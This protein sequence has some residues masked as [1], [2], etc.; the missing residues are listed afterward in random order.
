VQLRNGFLTFVRERAEQ[1]DVFAR[2]ALNYTLMNRLSGT[3]IKERAD[4]VI[5]GRQ[6]VSVEWL[7]QFLVQRFSYHEAQLIRNV[8]TNSFDPVVNLEEM[9]GLISAISKLSHRF[10]GKITLLEVDEFDGNR[11]SIEFV[12]G[13]INS[14]IPA[15]VMLLISTPSGYAEVQNSNPSVFDRLE[16][17][18]Y[19]VDLAGSNSGEELA[20][21]A[22]EYVRHSEKRGKFGPQQENGL[23][24]R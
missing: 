4:D 7:R 6:Q 18:N 23:A 20:E 9:I 2:K 13:M 11:D 24:E 5:L 3:T 21:I 17:A 1:G 19:K 22:A 15:C 8:I 14:H 10:L 12:K 16:K